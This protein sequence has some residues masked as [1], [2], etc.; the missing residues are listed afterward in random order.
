MW[1]VGRSVTVYPKYPDLSNSVTGIVKNYTSR[2][3]TIKL[4]KC[5]GPTSTT[6]F[7][8][9]NIA[10]RLNDI[11]GLE[12]NIKWGSNWITGK[13]MGP[14]PHNTNVFISYTDGD[15]L[16]TELSDQHYFIKGSPEMEYTPNQGFRLSSS[17]RE[18]SRQSGQLVQ[19]IGELTGH[20]S[21]EEVQQALEL[22][23]HKIPEAIRYLQTSRQSKE[24]EAQQWIEN[25]PMSMIN[26]N[27]SVKWRPGQ[28]YRGYIQSYDQGSGCFDIQYEDG[29]QEWVDLTKYS[30]ILLGLIPVAL[31][32][33]I[34]ESLPNSHISNS[35]LSGQHVIPGDVPVYGL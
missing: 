30:V 13:V 23:K 2:T 6:A 5:H 21:Q 20:P 22:M 1:I 17:P 34:L 35:S 18:F 11:L 31:P 29:D 8:I 24:E 7:N 26:Y 3:T 12:L 19:Q 14:H 9:S 16:W 27:I 28:W 4:K 10:F 32:P 33:P 15:Q 25:D